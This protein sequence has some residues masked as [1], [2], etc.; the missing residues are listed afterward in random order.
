MLTAPLNEDPGDTDFGAGDP[1]QLALQA[2][3]ISGVLCR[4]RGLGLVR[5][6]DWE[7][8]AENND[9]PPSTYRGDPI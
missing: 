7:E 8:V 1:Q 4:S 2:M 5:P 9:E 3:V 6:L